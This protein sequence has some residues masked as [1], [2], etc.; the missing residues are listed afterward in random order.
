MSEDTMKDK[1]KKGLEEEIRQEADDR[2]IDLDEAKKE[3]DKVVSEGEKAVEKEADK[4]AEEKAPSESGDAVSVDEVDSAAAADEPKPRK[5][6]HKKRK[7]VVREELSLDDAEEF[8]EED[9]ELSA[10]EGEEYIDET[11]EEEEEEMSEEEKAMR[12]KKR[13][14]VLKIVFGSLAGIIAAVYLGFAFFFMSHFHF[15]TKIN[16]VNFSMASVSDV[17]AYME[18]QVKGYTLT[19]KESDGGSE[20]ISGSEISLAYKK[21]DELAKLVKEQNAFLWP[22]SLWKTPEIEASVGVEYDEKK[23]DEKVAALECMKEENQVPPVSARPE[24]D[25][26]QFVPKAE[27]IG[28]QIEKETF[29]KKIKEYISGFRDTMDMTKESCYVKPKFNSKSK[30]V[31]DACTA[32]NQYMKA[33]VTYT[34]GSATEVVDAAVISQWVTTDDNMAVTFNSDAVKQYIQGLAD[35]YNTYQKQR[36]FTSGNGY[37]VTVEGGDYGWI[38]DQDTEYQALTASIQNGEQVTKE[39]AYTQT[40]ASHDGPDWGSTYVEVDLTNQ[41][42]YLFVN[43]GIVTSGPIVT[44]KPSIGDATP[45]GVYT[46][47]YCQANATLRGPK[48]PDGSYEWESPVS[49]WMPFNG[50][51]GLHDAPWQAAFGGSRYLTHGSHGC[52]NLQYD[53]AQTIFNNVTSGTPV[54]CHY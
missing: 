27:E 21:G 26:T 9:V 3:M 14:K 37:A 23:L 49:F 33:S 20:T 22:M 47:K 36:S 12:R 52:V 41:Y 28:S 4:G 1:E 18:E 25:G 7:K 54:V 24:F 10:E 38:I 8:L 43:G 2:G 35:K 13:G 32:M 53:V 45:P 48:Q 17:E 40:A 50:G 42:C 11:F 46:V 34:F 31:A 29:S 16:G 39:P 6:R 5:K 30:E 44:G 51:I 19:M 15:Q